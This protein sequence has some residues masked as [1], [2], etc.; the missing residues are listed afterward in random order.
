MFQHI[1]HAITSLLTG[2][3]YNDKLRITNIIC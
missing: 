1:V 3:N 2:S